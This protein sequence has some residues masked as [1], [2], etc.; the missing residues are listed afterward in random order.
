[1]QRLA[2]RLAA[3]IGGLA[4]VISTV[5]ASATVTFD[6]VTV[7][8]PGNARDP[9]TR[10]GAVAEEYRIAT[11]EVSYA[12]YAEFLNAV[13]PSAANALRLYNTSMRSNT[14]GGI[15]LVAGN[16]AGSRYVPVAGRENLPVNRVSWFDAA[17]FAN[18]LHN[19]Q[20]NGSTE[21][22]AYDFGPL[23]ANNE[24]LDPRSIGRNPNA[25]VFLPSEDEWYKAA[26]HN[27]AAGTAGSYFLY[28][29]G[30]NAEPI[31]DHPDD[32]P[33]AVNYVNDDGIDNGFNDGYAMSRSTRFPIPGHSPVGA[34][35]QAASPYGTFDQSGNVWEWTDTGLGPLRRLRGG[36]WRSS[37]SILNARSVQPT[38]GSPHTSEDE[39]IGFRVAAAVAISG[40]PGDYNNNGQVEQGDLDLVLQNWGLDSNGGS[41]TGWSNDLPDGVID[42]AELDG[43]LQNWGGTAAPDLRGTSVP[44]PATA[45][46]LGLCAL[47][48]RPWRTRKARG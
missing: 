41:P 34:Y 21:T 33:F 27:A 26:Y 29:T 15:D 8:N 23:D 45:A 18:W 32:N 30:S 3:T 10:H 37:A 5:A 14:G 47:V 36:S 42:Q 2:P 35:T 40:L 46:L 16:P 24:P 43:V 6:F 17:R 28:A 31:S 19:G 1:M 48:V 7:G 11:T 9:V 12:Q 39:Q 13:D 25:E 38:T 44:E 22:G 4:V 20:G